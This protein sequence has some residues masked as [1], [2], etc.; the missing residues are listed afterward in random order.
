[1]KTV[2]YP[3]TGKKEIVQV[4][5][6]FAVDGGATGVINLMKAQDALV[7]TAAH[8]VVKT[9][10]TSGGSATVKIGITGNDDLLFG[11]TTGAVANL[12]DNALIAPDVVEG[13]PNVVAFP[14]KIA[15]GDY[16]LMTIGTAALTAGKIVVTL[17]VMKL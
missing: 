5:Y 12:T 17:E 1:M 9:A 3:F 6:D 10:C 7:I 8:A 4:T 2:G 14:A 11:T 15:A 13:T 16:V